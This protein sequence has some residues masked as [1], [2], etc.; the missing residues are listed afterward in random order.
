M[1]NPNIDTASSCVHSIDDVLNG[2]E[3]KYG[4]NINASLISRR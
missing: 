2:N 3:R 1:I 4:V